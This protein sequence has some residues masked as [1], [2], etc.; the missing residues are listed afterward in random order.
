[1]PTIKGSLNVIPRYR[2][3]E[4]QMHEHVRHILG[5]TKD[6]DPAASEDW[7][8][9]PITP[10]DEPT[11]IFL[12]A[13]GMDY[14]AIRRASHDDEEGV[15]ISFTPTSRDRYPDGSLPEQITLPATHPVINGNFSTTVTHS[16]EDIVRTSVES[17]EIL[18]HENLH[19]GIY[20]R[21][22]GYIERQLTIAGLPET[23]MQNIENRAGDITLGEV[24]N[25]SAYGDEGIC[26]IGGLIVQL[27]SRVVSAT[28]EMVSI[29]LHFDI[30]PNKE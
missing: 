12:A 30:D 7:R 9:E 29:V 5:T 6:G 24:I 26:E 16:P 1:M 3:N 8:D 15:E 17:V 10:D 20:C 14:D 2:P 19:W 13:M 21:R 27:A 28:T 18:I 22:K 25:L 11:R 4:G 23:V